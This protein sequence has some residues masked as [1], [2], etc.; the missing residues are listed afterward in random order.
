MSKANEVLKKYWGHDQLRPAQEKAIDAVLQQ[1][2]VIALLPTG[3]G[4]SI[5]FQIP[6]LMQEG[7]CIVVSP[8]I[9]LMQDQVDGLKRKGI[10]AMMLGGHLPF[11]ELNTLLDNCIYGNYKFL[12]LSP[13]R[14]LNELVLDRLKQMNINLVAIDEAHCISEWGH[15]FRPA[16]RK[17]AVLK[18]HLPHVNIIA[19]TA[20][21]TKRVLTDISDN[22]GL[23]DAE[24]IKISF[25]RHNISLQIK[26]S[27]DK[28]YELQNYLQAHPGV[29]IVYV[30]SRRLTLNLSQLL[31]NHNVGAKA[32]HGGMNTAQKERLLRDWQAEK[33]QVMVATNAFG[34]GIDKANV[35]HV[36]H[37][38]L[39]D[40]LESYYQEVGRAGR[41]G[42]AST[43]LL[44]YSDADILKLK[45]QFLA[46]APTPQTVKTIYKKLNSYL[47]IA[48]GEGQETLHNF[49][50]LTFCNTYNF[51]TYLVFNVLQFLDRLDVLTLSK[52]FNQRT[53]LYFKISNRAI[54]TFLDHNEKFQHLVQTLLRM[55]GGFF[56]YKTTVN[57]SYLEKKTGYRRERINELLEE[58]AHLDVID[59]TLADQDSSVEFLVPREDNFTIHP[60]VS[61]IEQYYK[62]KKFKIDALIQF[63]EN[64]TQCKVT[65][66]LAY[67]DEKEQSACGQCSVCLNAKKTTSAKRAELRQ[68]YQAIITTLKRDDTSSKQLHATL[69]YTEDLILFVLRRMLDRHEI[70]LTTKMDYHLN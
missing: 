67:F 64:D 1:Q 44:I 23:N 70:S 62:N 40:S 4:K 37:Y 61:Y 7:I 46:N 60:L 38:H 5:C 31:N 22:L 28:I 15:D 32:Y 69:P 8:L 24:I 41:D 66:L 30:R 20:T 47:A 26:K 33:F 34:M 51:N 45:D 29:S 16:Y 9:S 57:I 6:A 3:G 68:I 36:I 42:N 17:I 65:Q 50:F 18:E 43:A 13:E 39:P 59:L 53:E 25:A 48:Y 54:L 63:V 21:A 52:E 27:E 19:L 11:S 35:R 12:Y 55:Q 10:K 58:L 14:L 56:D 49:N 2:D